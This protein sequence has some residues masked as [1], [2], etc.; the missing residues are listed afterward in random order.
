MATI[1]ILSPVA[2][3]R[4]PEAGPDAAGERRLGPRIRLGLLSNGKPNTDH[5]IE[6]LLEVLDADDRIELRLRERKPSASEP[7]E[8]AVL[9]R[10]MSS[11]DL[12]VGAT[13]D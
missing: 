13:A 10:L 2:E 6:G 5:L 8:E 3:T 9:S 12:V 11:A 1:T 7:A 4:V